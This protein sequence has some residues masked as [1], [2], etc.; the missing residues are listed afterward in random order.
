MPSARSPAELYADSMGLICQRLHLLKSLPSDVPELADAETIALQVRKIVEGLAY[1]ALSGSEHRNK[2][3]IIGLR[4]K[5]GADVLRSLSKR[6]M[7]HLPKAQDL[8][9][10]TN[11]AYEIVISGRGDRDMTEIELIDAFKLAS[12]I[13]HERHPERLTLHGVRA[14]RDKL[15]SITS[16]MR[17]WLWTHMV[18]HRGEAIVVQMALYPKEG[19]CGTASKLADAAG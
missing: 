6:G 4:S 12:Q 19:W 1:A 8:S 9:R 14:D 15:R 18:S 5:D 16:K 7:L 2:E 17:E 3:V 13:I 10:A 11:P